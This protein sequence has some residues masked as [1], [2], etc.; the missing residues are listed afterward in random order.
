[1]QLTGTSSQTKI[2]VTQKKLPES[3]LDNSQL[4][5][6]V[7]SDNI[8]NNNISSNNNDA[9]SNM[10]SIG[11]DDMLTQVRKNKHKEYISYISTELSN[12][13]SMLSTTELYVSTLMQK[14]GNQEHN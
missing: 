6:V 5:D 7:V 1:M 14:N 13:L 11:I 3:I 2:T 8:A 10:T 12:T 4:T 9:L